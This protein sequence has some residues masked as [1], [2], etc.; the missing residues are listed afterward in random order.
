MRKLLRVGE[1]GKTK[2]KPNI[3]MTSEL[4]IQVKLMQALIPI[5]LEA[6]GEVLAQEVVRFTSAE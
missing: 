5:R 1:K 2:L 4:Q 3:T 6:V